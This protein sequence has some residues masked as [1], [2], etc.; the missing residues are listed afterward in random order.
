MKINRKALY[1]VVS[2]LVVVVFIAAMTKTK[3]GYI[4]SSLPNTNAAP[5]SNQC[6]P[7][8]QNH[9]YHPDRLKLIKACITVTG[10]IDGIKKEADGDD[11][12]RLKLDPPFA[13]L[14]NA[15]NISVQHGDLVIEPI[16]LNTVTQTDA[17]DACMG[18]KTSFSIPQVGTHVSV[19]GPYVFDAPHGWNEIHPVNA[20]SP[21]P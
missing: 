9:V 18:A 11:H 15:K 4:A 19:T 13:S 14:I 1:L 12:I 16:C 17:V 5:D 21:A 20:I 6:D 10:T 3:Q 2:A 7:S 8:L